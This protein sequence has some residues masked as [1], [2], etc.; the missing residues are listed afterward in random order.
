MSY[1]SEDKD[2][3]YDTLKSING[4]GI[5]QPLIPLTHLSQEKIDEIEKEYGKLYPGLVITK[6]DWKKFWKY[7][8]DIQE[9]PDNTAS[10]YDGKYHKNLIGEDGNYDIEKDLEKY[11]FV[12]RR[13]TFILW[14]AIE[15][16]KTVALQ[17]RH[18]L[19]EEIE[20]LEDKIEELKEEI[21][22]LKSKWVYIFL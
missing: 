12:S 13:E 20:T 11:K 16:I 19:E 21:K 22:N 14:N 18:T 17:T 10:F 3:E 6:E 9:D 5:Q 1:F 8:K 4:G 15:R 7:Y 2:R